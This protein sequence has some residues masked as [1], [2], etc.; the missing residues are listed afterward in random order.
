MRMSNYEDTRNKKQ[1]T[2]GQNQVKFRILLLLTITRTLKRETRSTFK[3]RAKRASFHRSWIIDRGQVETV[4]IHYSAFRLQSKS[5]FQHPIRVEENTF[6]QSFPIMLKQTTAQPRIR[7]P[8][9]FIWHLLTTLRY[10]LPKLSKG[11]R[12][13]NL[14]GG[15]KPWDCLD[16]MRMEK[17]S[18]DSRKQS[19]SLNAY[20]Q[21]QLKPPKET[22]RRNEIRSMWNIFRA[23][24]LIYGDGDLCHAISN[25]CHVILTFGPY[26]AILTVTVCVCGVFLWFRPRNH[27][28]RCN[29]VYCQSTWSTLE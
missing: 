2:T 8:R 3:Q 12:H 27:L 11:R 23:C 9:D 15:K 14:S 4:G 10:K 13:S 22:K 7:L 6:N 26:H 29:G 28:C 18:H 16:K 17:T 1:L 21:L 20:L 5:K 24:L 25:V 19:H